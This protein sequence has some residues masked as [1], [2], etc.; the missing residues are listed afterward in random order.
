MAKYTHSKC[1]PSADS[2][3]ES[4]HFCFFP[5]SFGCAYTIHILI[6]LDI[7]WV[8]CVDPLLCIHFIKLRG[9]CQILYQY[10]F[11]LL[12][13]HHCD[14]DSSQ[15]DKHTNE[16]KKTQRMIFCIE[17]NEKRKTWKTI[18]MESMKRNRWNGLQFSFHPSFFI[19]KVWLKMCFYFAYDIWNPKH[20]FSFS[21]EIARHPIIKSQENGTKEK[22]WW[23]FLNKF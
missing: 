19:V 1:F 9:H 3:P 11:S 16:N 2:C 13:F 21:C 4:N 10:S 14:R 22:R 20:S 6:F 7:V 12:P 5:L 15:L 17:S 23:Q 8:F 18:R